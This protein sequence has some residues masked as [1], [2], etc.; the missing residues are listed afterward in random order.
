MLEV[1]LFHRLHFC[2][3]VSLRTNAES[4]IYHTNSN[5]DCHVS[6]YHSLTVAEHLWFYSRLKGLTADAVETEVDSFVRELALVH[7]RDEYSCNLS[8][9]PLATD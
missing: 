7:K 4:L 6:L 5:N 9:E 8:G 1:K 2:L 3:E